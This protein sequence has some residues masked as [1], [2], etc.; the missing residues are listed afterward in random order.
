M[1]GCG[2]E[3]GLVGL[4]Q[5]EMKTSVVLSSRAGRRIE[6]LRRVQVTCGERSDEDVT[7]GWNDWNLSPKMLG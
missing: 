4:I 1:I 5:C 7:I 2:F 6:K 3:G